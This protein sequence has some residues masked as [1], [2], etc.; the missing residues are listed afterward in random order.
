MGVAYLLR[1]ITSVNIGNS[2]FW[3]KLQFYF[4]SFPELGSTQGC[5]KRVDRVDNGP[6]GPKGP[7]APN[8]NE[9]IGL[10]APHCSLFIGPEGLATA[11]VQPLSIA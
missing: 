4:G 1:E 2:Q 6:S 3:R 8:Q 5:S 7:G 10:R 9:P 11:G